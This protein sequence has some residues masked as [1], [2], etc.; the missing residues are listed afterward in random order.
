MHCGYVHFSCTS[1]NHLILDNSLYFLFRRNSLNFHTRY[2]CSCFTWIFFFF[3][4]LSQQK[5]GHLDQQKQK[6]NP[7]ETIGYSVFIRGLK[8]TP[9][10]PPPSSETST[11]S[12]RPPPPAPFFLSPPITNVQTPPPCHSFVLVSQRSAEGRRGPKWPSRSSTI[13]GSLTESLEGRRVFGQGLLESRWLFFF[14][15]QRRFKSADVFSNIRT[16]FFLEK[17]IK[18]SPLVKVKRAWFATREWPFNFILGL[19]VLSLLSGSNKLCFLFIQNSYFLFFEFKLFT[20]PWQ[21]ACST[22]F[23]PFHW[24]LRFFACVCRIVDSISRDICKTA[25]LPDAWKSCTLALAQYQFW[26]FFLT[27]GTGFALS[28]VPGTFTI[29]TTTPFFNESAAKLSNLQQ[30]FWCCRT[31]IRLLPLLPLSLSPPSRSP[32]PLL[33]H[34]P[35]KW[36]LAGIGWDWW[37][38]GRWN[39]CQLVWSGPERVTAITAAAVSILLIVRPRW[40]RLRLHLSVSR[41]SV[42]PHWAKIAFNSV[43][44]EKCNG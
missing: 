33:P 28:G 31:E 32:S 11:F 2:R 12:Q 13:S 42:Q 30:V 39:R 17:K 19:V 38:Y 41:N 7:R 25:S 8:S 27:H 21:S 20:L 6:K 44:I 29:F 5:L 37:K 16:I 40:E 23:A 15:S 24:C 9:I 4:T 3:K 14:I 43:W 22:T 34:P 26:N 10:T 36:L 35:F 18:I 1:H